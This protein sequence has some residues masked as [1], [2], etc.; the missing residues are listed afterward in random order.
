MFGALAFKKQ[1]IVVKRHLDREENSPCISQDSLKK[2]FFKSKT[3]K[4]IAT[5]SLSH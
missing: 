3:R 5:S 1:I 2:I 4:K